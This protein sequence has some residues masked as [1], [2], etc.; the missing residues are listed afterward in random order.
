VGHQRQHEHESHS[1]DPAVPP[2]V[3]ARSGVSN[4]ALARLMRSS[5]PGGQAEGGPLDPAVASSIEQARGGGDA[6]PESTQASLGPAFGGDLSAVRVHAGDQ[7]HRLNQSVG[8]EAFTVGSDIFF[9]NGSYDPGSGAGQELLAHELTHVV[10]QA[11]SSGPAGTVAAVDDPAEA[12]ARQVAGLFS[13]GLDP[14]GGN[15]SVARLA[16][17]VQRA[18][19]DTGAPPQT[20]LQKL[21]EM[22][23]RFNVPE[24]EVITLIT[25]MSPTDKQIVAIVPS[26][27][28][29]LADALNFDEM[30]RLVRVLPLTLEL[31]LI[32]LRDAAKMIAAI[33]YDEIRPY[34]LA[35]P[36]SE[37]NALRTPAWLDFFML[38]CDNATM[39]AAVTDL[40]FPLPDKLRWMMAEGTD[41]AAVKRVITAAPDKAVALADQALLL[42]MESEVNWDDF[43]K[44]VELL[45]RVIPGPG[46]LIADAAVQAA[47]ASAWATSNAA[48]TSPPPA[49][50][51][52]GVHEEGGFIYL[53]II[54]NV[55]TTDRVA[56]GAQASLPLN[57]PS[58]PDHAVTVGGYHTH[59]NVGPPWGAPFASGADGRWATRNGIPLLIRGAFPTVAA[60][61]DTSTGSARR[62]LA[63]DRGFPGAAGGTPPQAPLDGEHE[64]EV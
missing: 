11:D 16:A 28:A 49:P 42:A 3:A 30:S 23:D 2:A 35:A 53:N 7:A 6:L 17:V 19:A 26:Y 20:D 40:G 64:D 15:R 45:G 29:L 34:V 18:P 10:Q 32:W 48:L 57:D 13:S 14:A 47:L 1:G 4:A 36:Q 24:D 61:S 25:A 44:S 5:A 54:T 8:A 38:V 27:R 21:G 39:E 12:H 22:L 62:H 33:G 31:K 9:S 46:A 52:P 56:P 51:T 60:T 63:G 41:Y 59:P 37:R 55:L 43:A 58:P 50:P